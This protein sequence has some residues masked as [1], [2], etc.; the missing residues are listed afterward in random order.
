[1]NPGVCIKDL[2][3]AMYEELASSVACGE[4]TLVQGEK[5][6]MGEFPRYSI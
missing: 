6:W 4:R 3:K 5:E 1:M 2:W